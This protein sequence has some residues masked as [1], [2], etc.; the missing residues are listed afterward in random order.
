VRTRHRARGGVREGRAPMG[1]GGRWAWVVGRGWGQVD[2]KAY[3]RIVCAI[4]DIPV[5]TR[6]ATPVYTRH[7]T[8]VY[9]RHAP[10]V[11]T[12]SSSTLSLLVAR[13]PPHFAVAVCRASGCSVPARLLPRT[14]RAA[15]RW[16]CGC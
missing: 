8:P 16:P 13:L 1:L 9:T 2:L 3:A 4:L 15:W 14:P 12:T 11:Y 6:H 7:A 10:P 5:Y